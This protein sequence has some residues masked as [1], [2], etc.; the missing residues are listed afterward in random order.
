MNLW[1]TALIGFLVILG[2]SSLTA[3]KIDEE[4]PS[5]ELP[6]TPAKRAKVVVATPELKAS[7]E[8]TAEKVQ[9]GELGAIATP[10]GKRSLRIAAKKKK[11]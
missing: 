2:L 7:E 6:Q 1:Q 4:E 3:K 11:W 8:V 10:A 9:Q 5:K